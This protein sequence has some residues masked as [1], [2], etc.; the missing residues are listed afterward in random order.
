MNV[1]FLDK[2]GRDINHIQNKSIRRKVENVIFIFKAAKSLHEIRNVKK[3]QGFTNAYR[4]SVGDYRIG[5]Y[6]ENETIEFARIAHRK[7]IYRLFP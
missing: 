7:D 4:V 1:E 6:F 3:L 5:F 2:F